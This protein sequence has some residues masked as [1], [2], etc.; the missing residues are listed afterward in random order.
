MSDD[1]A[2]VGR[3]GRLE[4]SLAT[5]S[6]EF[7]GVKVTIDNQSRDLSSI[8][9]AVGSLDEKLDRSRPGIGAIW[10]PLGAMVAVLSLIGGAIAVPQLQRVERIEVARDRE[11]EQLVTLR[12]DQ[13]VTRDRLERNH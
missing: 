6:T 7:A 2:M 4:N 5:L 10:A 9:S 11:A 13:A 3:V 8:A 12:I 1:T